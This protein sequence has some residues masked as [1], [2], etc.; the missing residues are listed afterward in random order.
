MFL[1]SYPVLLGSGVEETTEVKYED[2]ERE[3]QGESEPGEN[4]RT[5]GDDN[6]FHKQWGWIVLV[7]TLANNDRTKWE[8]I[9][10]MQVVEFLNTISFYKDKASYDKQMNEKS[11]RNGYR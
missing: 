10:S 4:D 6:W 3:L 7:N 2:I 9:L 8:D 11:M 1:G 5:T